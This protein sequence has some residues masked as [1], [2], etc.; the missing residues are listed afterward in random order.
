M[1]SGDGGFGRGFGVNGNN[2]KNSVWKYSYLLV[3]S[4]FEMQTVI[5]ASFSKCFSQDTSTS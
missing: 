4:I 1:I 3:N 5:A 2:K